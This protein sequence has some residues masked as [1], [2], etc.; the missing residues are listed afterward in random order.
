MAIADRLRPDAAATVAQLTAQMR[1]APVLL[2]GDNARSAA[3]LAASVGIDDVRAELLP[4]DK[5][6][7]VHQL[8]A[9][10]DRVL[11]VGDGVNDAPALAAHTP[12]SPWVQQDPTLRWRPPTRSSLAMT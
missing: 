3:R 8:Q 10:G 12:A 6:T 1:R 2:T 11:L 5:V 7:A 9:Q 4:H